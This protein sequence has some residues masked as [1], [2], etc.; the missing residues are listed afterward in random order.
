MPETDTGAVDPG[1]AAVK[2]QRGEKQTLS[3]PRL[4]TAASMHTAA[5]ESGTAMLVLGP[6]PGSVLSHTGL[7][8]ALTGPYTVLLEDSLHTA[9]DQLPPFVWLGHNFLQSR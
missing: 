7:P 1:R 6:L 8:S 3:S 4:L 5:R 2:G 9:E